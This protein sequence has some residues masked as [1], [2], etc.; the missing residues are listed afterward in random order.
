MNKK[1]TLVFCIFSLILLASNAHA[2][3]IDR[4]APSAPGNLVIHDSPYDAD[5]NITLTWTAATDGPC[6]SSAVLYYKIY[7]SNDS[8]NFVLIGNTAST[9]FDDFS[10]LPEGKYYYRLT[11]VDNVIDNPHEGPPI[12]GSTIVGQAPPA[13]APPS[14]GGGGG[15]GG[16]TPTCTENWVCTWSECVNGIQTGTCIDQSKCGTSKNK[17]TES[18]SCEVIPTETPAGGTSEVTTPSGAQEG[19]GEVLPLGPSGFFLGL[20]TI[21]WITAI[22]AG[23]IIA[24]VIIFLAKRKGKK[25]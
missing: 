10:S 6:P 9:S 5:G 3:C 2:F 25:K 1:T 19:V 21:D 7:R 24:I 17:P 16:G 4:T 23:I 14:G 18:R 11:A 8:V 15:G 20:S 22:I 13:P 12:E